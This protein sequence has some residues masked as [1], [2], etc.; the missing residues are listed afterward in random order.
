MGRLFRSHPFPG[1][2]QGDGSAYNGLV[3]AA[4]AAA[5]GAGAAGWVPRRFGSSRY[6]RDLASECW[7]DIEIIHVH[8]MLEPEDWLINDDTDSIVISSY[9]YQIIRWELR[10]KTEAYLNH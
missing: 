3:L 6:V 1:E 5:A 2:V 8:R 9:I 10:N 7:D 4:G